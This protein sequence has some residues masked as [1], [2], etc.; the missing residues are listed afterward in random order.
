MISGIGII[1]IAIVNVSGIASQQWS[2]SLAVSV[3]VLLEMV[4]KRERGLPFL[5]LCPVIMAGFIFLN[6][7]RRRMEIRADVFGRWLHADKSIYAR[8]LAKLYQA[9]ETPAVMSRKRMVHPH[10]YDRLLAAGI[11][12]DFPRPDT[13]PPVWLAW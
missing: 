4:V 13:L 11:T 5:A 6:R 7:R 2:N 9:N 10:L 1:Y 3:K 8:A 12:P